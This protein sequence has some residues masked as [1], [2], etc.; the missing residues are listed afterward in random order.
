MRSSNNKMV[1]VTV[2]ALD[3]LHVTSINGSLNSSKQNR[4]YGLQIQ[5]N[6]GYLYYKDV[7][8]YD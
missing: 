7:F 3:Y 5:S 1:L 6:A 4:E 8:E 2:G